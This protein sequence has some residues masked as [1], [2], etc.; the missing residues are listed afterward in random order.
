MVIKEIVVSL[1]QID[2][3]NN[4]LMLFLGVEIMLLIEKD[5]RYIITDHK[6]KNFDLKFK[7]RNLL[8]VMEKDKSYVL[9][10][11]NEN[12]VDHLMGRI[13]LI[14]SGEDFL[15]VEIK[16][17]EEGYKTLV[18]EISDIQLG[19]SLNALT[20]K[21]ELLGIGMTPIPTEIGY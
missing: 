6:Y 11:D 14:N 18:R 15:I 19:V 4:C 1:F 7:T 16:F 20:H 13:K 8:E 21:N 12:K 5:G 9:L 3:N 17:F 10:R 2:F